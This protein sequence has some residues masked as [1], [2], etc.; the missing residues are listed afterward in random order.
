MRRG[1]P[2]IKNSPHRPPRT[3]PPSWAAFSFSGLTKAAFFGHGTGLLSERALLRKA[4]DCFAA[5][6][7]TVG[8][9]MRGRAAHSPRTETTRN[10]PTRLQHLLLCHGA[11]PAVRLAPKMVLVWWSSAQG[12]TTQQPARNGLSP[13]RQSDSDH[14]LC[15]PLRDAAPSNCCTVLLNILRARI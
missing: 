8:A 9:L 15:P 10:A 11:M 14:R 5:T 13:C 1:R 2:R 4:A 3:W 6:A 12:P 7:F